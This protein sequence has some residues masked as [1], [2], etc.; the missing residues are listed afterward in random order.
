MV[1][2]NIRNTLPVVVSH[3]VNVRALVSSY[4]KIPE[5]DCGVTVFSDSRLIYD[6]KPVEA[7]SLLNGRV[8]PCQST[9]GVFMQLKHSVTF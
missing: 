1:L 5:L 7:H 2:E 9:M 6:L 4:V 3:I 8:K